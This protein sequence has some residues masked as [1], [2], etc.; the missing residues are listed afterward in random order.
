MNR[1]EKKQQELKNLLDAIL[2]KQQIHEKVSKEV[3]LSVNTLQKVNKGERLIRDTDE[4]IN[5][6]DLIIK[7]YRKVINTKI[8]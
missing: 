4:N 2:T 7:T 1:I 6:L 5:K 8:K 3:N